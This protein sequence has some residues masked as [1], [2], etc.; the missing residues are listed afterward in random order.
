METNTIIVGAGP[1]GLAMAARLIK[2]GKTFH[3]LE[4]HGQVAQSWRNHYDRLHL[5]TPKSSSALPG[6]PF[7]KG[8]AKYPSR[9]EVV[10]YFEA[11]TEKMG[12][13]P[14]FN[15]R[16]E[17]VTQ[18]DGQWHL[19]TSQG[20]FFARNIIFACG[21]TNEPR[22]IS[23]P[24]MDTFSGRILHSSAYKTGANFKGQNVL[25][26]G[27]G[28]SACEIAI[29][30][31]EQGAT[32]SMS[33]RSRV[34]ILPKEILGIPVLGIGILTDWIPPRI[35]DAL[36]AP[37]IRAK[38]GRVTDLGLKKAP[39][40]PKVQITEHHQIPLLDIGTVDLI[41]KG[42]ITTYG[43]V[44]RIKD[45]LITFEDGRQDSFDAIILGTGYK[46]GLENLISLPEERLAD[47]QL[48][49]KE[50]RMCGEDNLFFLGYYTSPNGM[51]REIGIESAHIE[52]L[53]R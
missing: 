27:F 17:Q 12:I 40:G 51:L 33:V 26:I 23:K 31:H 36:F 32:P 16:I 28:N 2:V 18:K 8:I 47:I 11:Y 38:V 5:H 39:Y 48:P 20:E 52:P 53:I 7:G 41:K 9:Q 15:T 25:V 37:V 14:T 1:A 44:T 10:D 24:G 30:L 43:D 50:R 34:N 21:S 3:L 46:H 29:D 4:Q 42:K 13:T 45:R 35:A 22:I 49:I 6:L 19:Q